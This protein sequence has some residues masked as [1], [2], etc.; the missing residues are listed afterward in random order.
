MGKEVSF[1]KNDGFKLLFLVTTSISVSLEAFGQ[2]EWFFFFPNVFI[3]STSLILQ[4]CLYVLLIVCT[5]TI[6]GPLLITGLC[7]A[8][9]SKNSVLPQ[10]DLT[11]LHKM[12]QCTIC[13][14]CI[15][16]SFGSRFSFF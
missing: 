4:I 15:L 9:F 6:D 14:S 5:I 3:C 13:I 2:L 7:L 8:L 1:P 11:F 12:N 10:S 16:I